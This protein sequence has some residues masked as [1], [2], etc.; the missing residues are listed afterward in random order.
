MARRSAALT[1]ALALGAAGCLRPRGT[2]EEPTVVEV[3]LEGVRA[4]NAGKLRER[5]ATQA[6]GFWAWDVPY[7]LDPDAVAAD[8]R[9]VEAFYRD[10]GYYEAHAEVAVEPAGAGRV[11]VVFRVEEGRP[12]RVTKLTVNGLDAAPE[13]RT[14]AGVLPL[15]VGDVFS[16][17]A[18]DGAH[19]RIAEA[20][21]R[22]G[23]AT[24]EVTQQAVVLPEKA[25][26]EVTYDVKAGRRWRF[27][28][29]AVIA[30]AELPR[31]KILDQA[32]GAITPGAFWDESRLAD[33][34]ARVFQLGVFSGVRVTRA[35]PDEERGTIGVVVT[36]QRAP[37]RTLRA[38]PGLDLTPISWN[39]HALVGWQDRNF[40]G[41]L[42]KLT[43]EARVGYAWLPSPWLPIKQGP[44]GQL[45][46]EF[47]QPGAIAPW[48][49]ASVRIETERGIEQ[50]YDFQAE[51]LRLSFPLRLSSRWK[52]VPSY[53]FEI[54]TLSRYATLPTPGL[55]IGGP[56]LEN[57]KGSICLLTYFEQFIAW[58]GRDDPMYTTRGVYVS[59]SVQEGFEIE[60]YGYRYLR[61]LP[62]LRYFHPLWGRTVLALR[63]RVGALIPIAEPG[64]PPIIARF[65][66]GGPQSMRG[67]YPRRFGPM[68]LQ[69]TEWVPL[70]G[71]G[72]VDGTIELRFPIAGNLGGA[73]FV[74]YGSVSDASGSPTE[75]Q[76]ALDPANF[77][78]AAGFGLRYA[79]PIGPVR[80]DVAAR[81]PDRWSTS[82]DA[83]PAV[84]F[85]RWPD[86][87]FHREPIV[88][89]HLS[90]GEAF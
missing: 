52:V 39:I 57:C 53:N 75:W 42:R 50:G 56:T 13:A 36:I 55:T 66:A 5:L 73:V 58:D 88:A 40:I 82:S 20:L 61:F 72:L 24:A 54:Y 60:T 76:A 63:A 78:Y 68:A 79:T 44:V 18:Y 71:N 22:T 6:T 59:L 47:S 23:W 11:R 26:A 3:R 8:R 1:L 62:D 51:R 25:T 83:F 89:I 30:G 27:G 37:F 35:A 32:R 86:G 80:L 31:G 33:A 69:G 14:A 84:P 45:A 49:D 28:P 7:R 34:Q 90:L 87:A 74:D 2:P 15:R 48:L 64:A 17:A 65:A 19:A 29:I 4:V 81:L 9:R 43:A 21:S 38:G 46:L 16:V 10:Q 12:T 41:D 67:Y 77:Q 70:G 85:T